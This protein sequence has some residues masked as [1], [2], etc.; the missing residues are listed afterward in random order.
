MSCR[1]S[2]A[3]T[4]AM[5]SALPASFGHS[6]GTV[7]GQYGHRTGTVRA[8]EQ[9]RRFCVGAD[10]QL[11]HRLSTEQVVVGCVWRVGIGK[12]H[13]SSSLSGDEL[14]L[15]HYAEECQG[16]ECDRG[17]TS[18]AVASCRHRHQRMLVGRNEAPGPVRIRPRGLFAPM[19]RCAGQ[20]GEAKHNISTFDPIVQQ[21]QQVRNAQRQVRGIRTNAQGGTQGT[22]KGV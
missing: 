13:G 17:D 10:G 20:Y 11:P 12:P 4:R 9:L 1:T 22:H 7:R 21:H 3:S 18:V 14:I 16:V 5:A 15:M 6:S 8:H 19:T 2:S